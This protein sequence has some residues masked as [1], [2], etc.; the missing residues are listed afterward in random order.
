MIDEGGGD[1][2]VGVSRSLK[3]L[4]SDRDD[5]VGLIAYGLFKYEQ[6]EWAD[7]TRPARDAVD[8]H[9]EQLQ[10][11]RIESLR[12]N[13]E[14]RLT[15]WANSLEEQWREQQYQ[16]L[17]RNVFEEASDDIIRTVEKS[18]SFWKSVGASVVAWFASIVLTLVVVLIW[19]APS[20]QEMIK[21]AVN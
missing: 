4:S 5:I 2:I 21:R 14:L 13:A 11:T 8:R 16:L 7:K 10:S 15:K 18:S 9:H 12:S 20:L 19:F 17:A 6:S 1:H 3:K